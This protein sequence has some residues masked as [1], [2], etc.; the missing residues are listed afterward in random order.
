MTE[1]TSS[2]FDWGEIVQDTSSSGRAAQSAP[3][4]SGA[5]PKN[6]PPFPQGFSLMV[7]RLPLEGCT[8]GRAIV[9]LPK[10]TDGL[11]CASLSANVQISSD[12]ENDYS[13]E[14]LPK[15]KKV[16]AKNDRDILVE[17]ERG[18]DATVKGPGWTLSN[19]YPGALAETRTV[20]I[21]V[22][23]VDVR[24]WIGPECM[25]CDPETWS[26]EDNSWPQ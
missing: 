26:T 19:D 21:G 4:A 7:G 10:P 18:G 13:D 22:P 23:Y 12:C 5:Q 14:P 9:Q 6:L 8:P 17:F 20:Q 11:A 3:V 25:P 1:Q 2:G 16:I 15:V 24:V